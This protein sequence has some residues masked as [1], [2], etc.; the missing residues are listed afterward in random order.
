MLNQCVK[1]KIE[2]KSNKFIQAPFGWAFSSFLFAFPFVKGSKSV[3]S[4][5]IYKSIW[6]MSAFQNAVE[7]GFKIS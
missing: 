4:N 7:N 5:R 2:K 3:W 6:E 1:K